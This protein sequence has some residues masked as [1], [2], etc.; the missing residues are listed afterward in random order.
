[1]FGI[2]LPELFIILVIALVVLG[3]DK[4]PDLARAI[5]KGIGEFRRATDDIKQSFNSDDE[6]RELKT[7]LTQA[8]N[9]MTDLVKREAAGVDVDAITKAFAE[10]S[11]Q[12]E[13]Q[14]ADQ[15]EPGDGLEA[16]AEADAAKTEAAQAA[17]SGEPVQ[18]A[19]TGEETSV[20][21]PEQDKPST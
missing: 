5:G 14:A 18:T 1:M 3:P 8:K 16:D 2:G 7:S 20:G 4:L 10:G 6:L 19:A 21:T 15:S 13:K 12:P 17:V 11:E 9:E